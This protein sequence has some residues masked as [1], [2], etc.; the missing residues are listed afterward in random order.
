MTGGLT[1]FT[2]SDR[3]VVV[4]SRLSCTESW[5]ATT[6][7]SGTGDDHHHDAKA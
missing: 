5:P 7:P 1:V 3:V 2:P 4:P 6:A